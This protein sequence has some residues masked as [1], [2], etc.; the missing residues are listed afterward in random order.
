MAARH[1]CRHRD[2]ALHAAS[3]SLI[4][5]TGR[6]KPTRGRTVTVKND[7]MLDNLLIEFVWSREREVHDVLS[8][9]R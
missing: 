5:I 8:V 7:I 9:G 1:R 3:P 6:S 4:E 2:R